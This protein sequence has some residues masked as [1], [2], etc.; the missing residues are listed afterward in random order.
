MVTT[1]SNATSTAHL[2]FK[3][4]YVQKN[5]K[6]KYSLCE[7]RI[8]P[9]PLVTFITSNVLAPLVTFITSNAPAP[10]VTFITRNA[11]TTTR[12]ETRCTHV[13]GD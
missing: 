4:F 7:D 3:I 6:T 9:A 10:L 8:A 5:K 11:I 1:H 12:S 13:T 2:L